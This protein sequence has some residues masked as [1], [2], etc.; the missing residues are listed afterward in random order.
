MTPPQPTHTTHPDV[1]YPAAIVMSDIAGPF[2][3]KNAYHALLASTST[4]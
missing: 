3:S 1:T 4:L 2:Y